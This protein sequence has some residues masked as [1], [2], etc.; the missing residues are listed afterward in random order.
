MRGNKPIRCSTAQA[1]C[2]EC[3]RTFGNW[4]ITWGY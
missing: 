4:S 3:V 1:R 2:G